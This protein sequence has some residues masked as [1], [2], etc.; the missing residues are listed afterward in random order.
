M[1]RPAEQS[2]H[3]ASHQ[4]R[5][6]RSSH[7]HDRV[8]LVDLKPRVLERQAARLQRAFNDRRNQGLELGSGDVAAVAR[9][10]AGDRFDHDDGV[11]DIRQIPFRLDD[12]LAHRLHGAGLRL[13]VQAQIGRHQL[14]EDPVDVVA[15]QMRV[16]VGGQYLEHTILDS[17]NRDVECASA[18]IVDRNDTLAPLV[19]PVGE[20]R[21]GRLVDDAQ[22]LETGQPSG[23]PR[24]RALGVVEVGRDGNHRP[25]HLRVEFPGFR[26]PGFGPPLQFPKNNRRQFGRRQFAVAQV[27]V[28]HA[29]GLAAN[30]EGKPPRFAGDI[31]EAPAHEALHGVHRSRR[32]GQQPTLSL[33][34]HV[35]GTGRVDRDNRRQQAIARLVGEHHRRAI[36]HD[37]D[38]TVGGAEI[39]ANHVAHARAG[40]PPSISRRTA[41]SRLVR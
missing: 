41:A 6:R 8:H 37:G 38:Q 32:I 26:Q 11:V 9:R 15:A 30:L 7:Q 10:P 24:G 35:D 22:H 4:R 17:Q 13:W 23:I 28:N 21:G 25:I 3:L 1:R 2:L 16:A 5:A 19:E 33:A 29:A 31:I 12:S 36:T 34:P 18:E 39:D 40:A 27:H 14:D 20:A